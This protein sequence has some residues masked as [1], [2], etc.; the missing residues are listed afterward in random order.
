M[1]GGAF[2]DQKSSSAEQWCDGDAGLWRAEG[3]SSCPC[4][5][6]RLVSA[7]CDI[8]AKFFAVYRFFCVSLHSQRIKK[9]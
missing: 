7:S 4:S 2:Q 9:Y 6:T 8:I 5:A 3:A 1:H